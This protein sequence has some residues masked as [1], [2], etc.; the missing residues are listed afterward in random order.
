MS[1]SLSLRPAT[2]ADASRVF[3]VLYFS[4]KTLLPYAS[5]RT[6]D[7]VRNWTKTV[8][9]P[10]G[11]VTVAVEK[12]NVVGVVATKREDGAGWITQLYVA[13]EHVAQGVGTRMLSHA[14]DI[15]PRPVRLWCFQRN[16]RARRF[17]ERRGFAPIRFTDGSANEERLPDVLYELA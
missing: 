16:I 7:E 10:A 6:E 2:G 15:L 12:D 13:P 5:L 3:E 11:D 4:R 17:Y 1:Q 8:L 14:L 9:I